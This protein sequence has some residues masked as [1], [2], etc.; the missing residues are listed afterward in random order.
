MSDVEITKDYWDGTKSKSTAFYLDSVSASEL[1]FML[2]EKGVGS[3]TITKKTSL[4]RIVQFLKST[5]GQ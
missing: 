3:I 5:E 4:D 1:V 2:M